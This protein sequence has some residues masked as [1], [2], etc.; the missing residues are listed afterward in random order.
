MATRTKAQEKPTDRMLTITVNLTVSELSA[1]SQAAWVVI[2]PGEV[3]FINAADRAMRKFRE[4]AKRHPE[5][6]DKVK[7]QVR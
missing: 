1:A 7:G 6:P 4:A 5:T 2:S 3:G